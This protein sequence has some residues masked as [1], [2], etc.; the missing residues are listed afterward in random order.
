MTDTTTIDPRRELGPEPATTNEDD[1][2]FE[3]KNWDAGFYS[4]DE[5]EDE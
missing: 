1:D 2:D 3:E 4:P 5:P